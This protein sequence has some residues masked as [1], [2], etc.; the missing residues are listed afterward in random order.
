MNLPYLVGSI[1]VSVLL[2]LGWTVSPFVMG[3][4][5]YQMEFNGY[6]WSMDF[7][8]KHRLG[9]AYIILLLIF[10]YL[11]PLLAIVGIYV[12]ILHRM[13]RQS[14][15]TAS[16]L[17]TRKITI[18][19]ALSTGAFIAGWTP[20]ALL[21][22]I[23]FFGYT[24]GLNFVFV[25]NAA[26]KLSCVY[27]SS[28]FWASTYMGRARDSGGNKNN[29][30]TCKDD[31]SDCSRRSSRGRSLRQFSSTPPSAIFKGNRTGET[32][33]DHTQKPD[34]SQAPPAGHRDVN[35]FPP[36]KSPTRLEVRKSIHRSEHVDESV[37]S[38]K[39]N[40]VQ[41]KLAEPEKMEVEPQSTK[42]LSV[43]PDDTRSSC[44]SSV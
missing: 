36:K 9:R 1:V 17:K 24:P 13:I 22:I 15:Q 27:N 29:M 42:R 39:L 16:L 3:H 28:M 20:Y 43:L 19:C 23:S 2:S 38:K 33:T 26:A 14:R 34:Y 30:K 4:P 5:K 12:A 35:L 21:T 18:V 11:V 6:F 44:C 37:T 10:E 7:A 41:L 25:A 32:V 8:D 31:S 40:D